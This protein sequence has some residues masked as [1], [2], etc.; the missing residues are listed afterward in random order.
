MAIST[1]KAVINGQTITLTL[2]SSTGKYEATMTA[3]STSS[4]NVNDD[5]YYP[6]KITATDAAGNSTTVDDTSATLGASLKLKVKEKV[7][8]VIAITSPTAG[9]TITNNKPSITF[10]VTDNDSGVNADTIGITI[11]SGTKIT[12]GITKTAITG[13]YN[14]SYT[15]TS[16]LSDGGHTIKVDASDND[17]NAATQKSVTFT[18]DTVPPALSLTSPTDGLVTNKAACAV[19]GT[20]NDITSSPCTV[21]VKLNSG[22]AETATVSADGTFSKTVTLV[23]GA[24]TITVV[25]T[26]AAGKSTT[27]TRTVTLDTVA[28]T[29]TAVTLTPNP[30][31]CGATYII[32]VTVSD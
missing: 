19:S 4:Y 2:N 10:K 31:D 15:P 28:P 30:V 16:A 6:V 5:H 20:T 1:V 13:G 14:C 23:E 18:V 32:S 27:V 12:T 24:N 8:P 17:G 7:A 22:A 26:D 21:T 11:D 25:S 29:I 9:A 3:P